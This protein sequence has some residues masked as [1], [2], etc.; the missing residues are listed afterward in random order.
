VKLQTRFKLYLTARQKDGSWA[1]QKKK[2]IASVTHLQSTFLGERSGA[3][4]FLDSDIR[5]SECHRVGKGV[6]NANSDFIHRWVVCER[7]RC[8]IS[9]ADWLCIPTAGSDTVSNSLSDLWLLWRIR[10]AKIG[11][12][13]RS[14][15][16][17]LMNYQDAHRRGQ[18]EIDK[19]V[20]SG[21]LP[22]LR[23]RENLPYVTAFCKETLRLHVPAPLGNRLPSWKHVE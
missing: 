17:S 18:A 16:F 21:R 2:F 5:S 1:F 3:E 22:T 14:V 11:L 15:I 10:E 13:M 6:I 7:E 23:D 8:D 12:A 4:I 19:V 20:G 9:D